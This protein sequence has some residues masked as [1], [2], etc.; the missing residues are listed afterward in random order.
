MIG[1]F[2]P[3]VFALKVIRCVQGRNPVGEVVADASA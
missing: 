1:E 2:C 3:K